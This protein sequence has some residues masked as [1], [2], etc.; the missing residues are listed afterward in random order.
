LEARP[1]VDPQTD[2]YAIVAAHVARVRQPYGAPDD[3]A[4]KQFPRTLA[5]L[6]DREL[7]GGKRRDVPK[8]LLEATPQGWKAVLTDYT[9][10]YKCT[11]EFRHFSEL[12]ETLEMAFAGKAGSWQE[13]QAGEGAKARKQA[14]QERLKDAPD[15]LYNMAR[16]R[17]RKG[18]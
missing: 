1:P 15:P 18:K 8:L 17:E 9:L 10:S 4:R 11:I 6:T 14:E 5:F 2:P 7:P 12:L 16:G 13:S 3:P